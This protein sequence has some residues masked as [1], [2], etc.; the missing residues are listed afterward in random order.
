MRQRAEGECEAEAALKITAAVCVQKTCSYVAEISDGA[1]DERQPPAITVLVPSAG[2]TLWS[3]AKRLKL[4]PEEV[5]E[6]C[7][8]TSF[9]LSGEERIVIYRPKK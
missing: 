3:A 5:A 1:D 7:G 2:E 8:G 6:A 4:S 9:P